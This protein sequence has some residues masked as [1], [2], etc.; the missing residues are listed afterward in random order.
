MQNM[1]YATILFN[2]I[3]KHLIGLNSENSCIQNF[4]LFNHE[5]NQKQKKLNLGKTLKAFI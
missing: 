3:M 2:A 1:L 5:E 4:K